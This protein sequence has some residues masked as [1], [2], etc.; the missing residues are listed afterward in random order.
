MK[1]KT[2]TNLRSANKNRVLPNVALAAHKASIV[3]AAKTVK[4]ANAH[5]FE[6]PSRTYGGSHV[7]GSLDDNFGDD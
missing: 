4:A 5:K 3:K 6:F 7:S 1:T 2:N